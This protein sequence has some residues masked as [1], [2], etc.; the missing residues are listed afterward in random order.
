VAPGADPL[1]KDAVAALA[2]YGGPARP[3]AQPGLVDAHTLFTGQILSAR[4]VR[5]VFQ[6]EG[7][8]D[9]DQPGPGSDLR[10]HPT[11]CLR[12]LRRT[13]EVLRAAQIPSVSPQGALRVPET[14]TAIANE[15]ET[16]VQELEL[17]VPESVV[18]RSDTDL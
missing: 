18:I 15:I 11:E 1:P 6:F 8:L 10:S 2:A 16:R 7:Q 9:L 5:A 13:D 17:L 14:F 3:R 12:H 4:H